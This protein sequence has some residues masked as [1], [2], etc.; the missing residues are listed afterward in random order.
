MAN[1]TRTFNFA[2]VGGGVIS[3]P[4]RYRGSR[5][6]VERV[7]QSTSEYERTSLGFI[8]IK[9]TIHTGTYDFPMSGWL[10]TQDEIDVIM[11]GFVLCNRGRRLLDSKDQFQFLLEDEFEELG[12]SYPPERAYVPG[13]LRVIN[14]GISTIS[15]I[16]PICKVVFKS[17][18]TWRCVGDSADGD[19]YEIN[20]V[21][22][23]GDIYLASQQLTPPT[24]TFS[25]SGT[26]SANTNTSGGPVQ[27]AVVS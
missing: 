21:L 13:S 20:L 24:T 8:G 26:L 19:L 15:A 22:E 18:P 1:K 17:E 16:K 10:F 4:F 27:F 7:P 14:E 3:V 25:L 2:G 11:S 23:E 6:Q 9:G 5:P 12:D